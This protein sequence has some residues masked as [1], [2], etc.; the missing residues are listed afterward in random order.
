M[1]QPELQKA[2]S[3][4]TMGILIAFGGGGREAN[5]VLRYAAVLL[6]TLNTTINVLVEQI[7]SQ[8]GT[9]SS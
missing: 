2:I 9:A 5:R 4:L 6:D 3:D 8:L 7:N 1:N